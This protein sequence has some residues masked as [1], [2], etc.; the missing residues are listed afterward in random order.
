MKMHG[1]GFFIENRTLSATECRPESAQGHHGQSSRLPSNGKNIPTLRYPTLSEFPELF[2]ATF[3]RHGGQ[4]KPPFKSLNISP[5]V[6]DAHEDVSDNLALLKTIS[7]AK[8]LLFTKQVH[9]CSVLVAEQG[10]ACKMGETVEGD[11]II[12]NTPGIAIM[13]MQADCQGVI[14]YDPENGVVAT[15]HCGWR[16]HVQ[17]ILSHVVT[18][19]QSLF[20]TQAGRLQAAIGPSL[21]PCCAEF[22]G[23]KELFPK[24]F[25]EFMIR[26]NYFNLWNIS[27]KQLEISG[28]NKK[29][30]GVAGICTKCETDQFF[31]YRGE[32]LTGRFG[33]VAMIR[34]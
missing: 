10:S 28:L 13:V 9:G 32:G 34:N 29:N 7:H 15:V 2:H 21:G 23:Y 31:S 16:G 17:N 30:I 5:S 22:K 19:M 14:L 4:S 27:V 33:T 12:T 26:E 11:A 1:Q 3:T 24:H 18:K 20:G 8:E 25:R 6:G